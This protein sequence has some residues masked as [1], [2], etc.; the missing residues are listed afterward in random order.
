[1][2]RTLRK[3]AGALGPQEIIKHDKVILIRNGTREGYDRTSGNRFEAYLANGEV[4][5]VKTEKVVN[6]P[7]GRSPVK[8]LLFAGRPTEH[9]FGFWKEEFG[10]EGRDGIIEL[11][12]ALTV[13]KA[14]GS[15]FGVVIVILPQGRM[16]YRELI[17]TAITR[18]KEQ[19]VLLVQGG[20][21]ADLI[22]MSKPRASDTIRRNTNLFRV[23]VRDGLDRPFARHLVHQASDGELLRSKSELLI[24]SRCLDA[25]LRPMYERRME[26]P[27]GTWKWPDFTFVDAADE[28]IVWKHLGM[29]D[30]R[31]YADDWQRKKQWYERQGLVEGETLFWTQER[32][33][34]NVA[35]IDQTIEQVK[36]IV[37]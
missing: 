27:D 9:T 31:S 10:G 3:H 37:S 2:K 1:M 13:H 11:A 35:D 20:N 33:G 32:G 17:Y 26:A 6:T 22:E 15:E 19:L 14:Q 25:G 34:L 18:S 21:V 5:L 12:Y 16:A 30:D 24:Y 29:L 23:A 36:R 8:N 4:A 7:H 28:P